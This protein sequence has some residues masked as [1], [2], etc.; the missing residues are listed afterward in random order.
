MCILGF[1]FDLEINE[2]ILIDVD[3][4]YKFEVGL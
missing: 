2:D 4:W 1:Y 3:C